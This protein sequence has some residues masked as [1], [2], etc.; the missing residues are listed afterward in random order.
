[1]AITLRQF[2]QRQGDVRE[3]EIA[4]DKGG[5]Q[6]KMMAE[7]EQK[8]YRE[9]GELTQHFQILVEELWQTALRG[10]EHT[11]PKN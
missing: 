9:L 10:R 6:G 2:R 3:K 5:K 4:R 7:E 1:M 11:Q 8:E